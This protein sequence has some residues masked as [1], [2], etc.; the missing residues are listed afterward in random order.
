VIGSA[1]PSGS[2]SRSNTTSITPDCCRVAGRATLTTPR[3]RLPDGMTEYSSTPTVSLTVVSNVSPLFAEA[4]WS[5]DVVRT[6]MTLPA[7]SMMRDCAP[8]GAA[9]STSAAP[10]LHATRR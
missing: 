5:G 3:I 8:S 2:V 9:A 6:T 1:V 7:G 4:D 10:T